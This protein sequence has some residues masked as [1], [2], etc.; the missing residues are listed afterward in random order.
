[1]KKTGLALS[2]IGILLLLTHIFIME[3]NGNNDFFFLVPIGLLM[4]F[5]GIFLNNRGK[6]KD[7]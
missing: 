3:K 6:K 5:I 7:D 4:S 2:I 1:M